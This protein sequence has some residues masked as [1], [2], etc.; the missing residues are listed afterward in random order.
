MCGVT[1][2]IASAL[3]KT[4][5]DY[6]GNALDCQPDFSPVLLYQGFSGGFAVGGIQA[7]HF[8]A[9]PKALRGWIQKA[10]TVRMEEKGGWS[11]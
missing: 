5:L 7:G 4:N 8:A 6:T 9:R 10:F 1:G 3:R 11:I 2:L